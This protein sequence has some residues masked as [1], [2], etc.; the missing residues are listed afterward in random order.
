MY[1]LIWPGE[2]FVAYVY[3]SLKTHLKESGPDEFSPTEV[4]ALSLYLRDC[5]HIGINDLIKGP[6][7]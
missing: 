7:R 6:P 4:E 2:K 3:V 5:N 1:E